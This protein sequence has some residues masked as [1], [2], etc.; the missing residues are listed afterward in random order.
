MWK[1]LTL[2]ALF[3]STIA[4]SFAF[5]GDNKA[6]DSFPV[7][8]I[9]GKVATLN[10][11]VKDLKVGDTL[12]FVKSPYRFTVTE[13]KG[14]EVTISLPENHTLVEGSALLR[15]ITPAIKKNLDTEVKLKQALEE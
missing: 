8:K 4:S 12:Y 10:G 1:I 13:I 15:K 5:F 7:K 14:K 11:T 6:D 9:E 3:Y 2:T